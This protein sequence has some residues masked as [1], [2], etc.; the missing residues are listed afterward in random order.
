MLEELRLL[1]NHHMD[2]ESL[3]TLVLVG[4]SELR[5]KLRLAIHEPLF[6]RLAVRYHLGPLDL[7]ET[8]AYVK[9]HVRV[10]GYTGG[11]LFSDEF[12]AKAFDYT[13]GI[14][15]KINLVCVHAL[16][17]GFVDRK[18]IIDEATLRRAINDL[19]MD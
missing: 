2:A 1:L 10:A 4:H 11:Q 3:A 18:Q 16:M 17:A 5:R 9:H 12:V 14:P 19:E 13:K 8:A 6:Q 7:E 15:R